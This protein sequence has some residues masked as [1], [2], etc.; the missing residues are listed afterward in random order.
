MPELVNTLAEHRGHGLAAATVSLAAREALAAGCDM[1]F[2]VCAAAD[3]PVALYARLG[4]R[5]AGRFWSFT[6]PA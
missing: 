6:R 3:G 4:F 5:A 1:V 2:I